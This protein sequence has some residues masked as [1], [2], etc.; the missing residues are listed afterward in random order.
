MT[1]SKKKLFVILIIIL[2]P[3]II[4]VGIFS[5]SAEE[6]NSG[7]NIE[8]IDLGNGW[9]YKIS[10]NNKMFIYQDNIPAINGNYKFPTK[11]AAKAAATLVRDKLLSKE[12]PSLSIEELIEIG[13]LNKDKTPVE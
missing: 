1:N 10:R 13:V 4:L 2:L 12:L 5:S 11:A 8:V 6:E 7:L 3:A 9:G